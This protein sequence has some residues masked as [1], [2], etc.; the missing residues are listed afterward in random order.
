MESTSSGDVQPLGLIEQDDKTSLEAPQIDSDSIIE[1]YSETAETDGADSAAEDQRPNDNAEGAAIGAGT[2]NVELTGPKESSSKVVSDTTKEGILENSRIDEALPTTVSV[3]K[4]D[5]STSPSPVSPQA[6]QSFLQNL[7]PHITPAQILKQFPQLSKL[8]EVKRLLS[9]SASASKRASILALPSNLV[10]DRQQFYEQQIVQQTEAADKGKDAFDIQ[11]YIESYFGISLEDLENDQ[12]SEDVN[13][14]NDQRRNSAIIPTPPMTPPNRQSPSRPPH[15][16]K[17][18]ILGKVHKTVRKMAS[19]WYLDRDDRK[20]FTPKEESSSETQVAVTA[21]FQSLHQLV[22]SVELLLASEESSVNLSDLNIIKPELKRMKCIIAELKNEYGADTDEGLMKFV[23]RAK[24]M[25]WWTQAGE[26]RKVVDKT[27]LREWDPVKQEGKE[28]SPEELEI[29]LLGSLLLKCHRFL[30]HHSTA[31]HSHPLPTLVAGSLDFNSLSEFALPLTNGSIFCHLFNEFALEKQCLKKEQQD[32]GS[33]TSND[34]LKIQPIFEGNCELYEKLENWRHFIRSCYSA[35]Y[36]DWEGDQLIPSGLDLFE[37]VT[38]SEIGKKDVIYALILFV[39]RLSDLC[40]I[41]PVITFDEIEQIR[42]VCR[43]VRNIPSTGANIL[44]DNPL[45]NHYL[46]S[47]P[48]NESSSIFLSQSMDGCSLLVQKLC[49]PK[50]QVLS[51]KS[52]L[53]D[54]IKSSEAEIEV[55][56][57]ETHDNRSKKRLN[58]GA[59]AKW[60]LKRLKRIILMLNSHNREEITKMISYYP[61]NSATRRPVENSQL[62]TIFPQSFLSSTHCY[63][64]LPLPEVSQKLTDFQEICT[65]KV[66]LSLTFHLPKSPSPKPGEWIIDRTK[67]YSNNDAL[68]CLLRQITDALVY[69]HEEWNLAH[70][71][72]RSDNILIQPSPSTN[73]LPHV[74]LTIPSLDVPPPPSFLQQ[75]SNRDS[76]L[77]DPR[78]LQEANAVSATPGA[79]LTGKYDSTLANDVKL[80]G[81]MIDEIS[82]AWWFSP[83]KISELPETESRTESA[84]ESVLNLDGGSEVG[85]NSGSESTRPPSFEKVKSSAR[86]RRQHSIQILHT[87]QQKRA[88]QYAA[89]NPEFARPAAP[90]PPLPNAPTSPLETSSPVE[91]EPEKVTEISTSSAQDDIPSRVS[92]LPEKQLPPINLPPKSS[93]QD[94]NQITQANRS[95]SFPDHFPHPDPTSTNTTRSQISSDPLMTGPQFIPTQLLRTKSRPRAQSNPKSR[96]SYHPS[97]GDSSKLQSTATSKSTAD[98]KGLYRQTMNPEMLGAAIVESWKNAEFLIPLRRDSDGSVR[99]EDKSKEG[100]KVVPKDDPKDVQNSEEIT[101]EASLISNT[102]AEGANAEDGKVEGLQEANDSPDLDGTSGGDLESRESIVQ[103]EDQK[104]IENRMIELTDNL[105]ELVARMVDEEEEKRPVMR[106]VQSWLA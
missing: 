40:D 34:S 54:N 97:T 53:G 87:I 15:P 86:L 63:F 65:L 61:S 57:S 32:N 23:D 85:S 14:Q 72:I 71:L 17:E 99:G 25:D 35:L 4:N 27:L 74:I 104:A 24:L 41:E 39:S 81:E 100:E 70:G 64:E 68:I 33:D 88:S 51:V 94:P 77:F 5:K 16:N 106:E 89:T 66:Y 90:L 37:I 19:Q 36:L 7:P 103:V 6:V 47:Y 62:P 45:E 55:S 59:D 1:N 95:T 105:K 50:Q 42:A 67:A 11:K 93:S 28:K 30:S 96:F 101:D 98:L 91:L 26:F 18:P 20:V 78:Q 102:E 58:T 84:T 75:S 31:I 8:P 82:R 46:Y 13:T 80:F 83:P 56:E 52:R 73:G 48:I 3:S 60:Y 9:L 29:K 2:D 44:D 69:L 21:L 76:I 43:Q 22:E 49:L 79:G 38:A 92:S 10:S 12:D